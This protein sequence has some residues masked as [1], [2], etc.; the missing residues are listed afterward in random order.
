MVDKGTAWTAVNIASIIAASGA[1]AAIIFISY[2]KNKN[3]NKHVSAWPVR[4]CLVLAAILQ[5]VSIMVWE[6]NSPFHDDEHEDS[7]AFQGTIPTYNWITSWS[8]AVSCVGFFIAAA[9]YKQ[10]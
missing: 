2:K 3:T 9:I 8:N 4:T 7:I 5:G 6:I 1:I 10:A